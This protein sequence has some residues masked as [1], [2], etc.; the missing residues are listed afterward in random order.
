[1][2]VVNMKKINH[3]HLKTIMVLEHFYEGWLQILILSRIIVQIIGVTFYPPLECKQ[4]N[5]SL[6]LYVFILSN[7]NFKN[8]INFVIFIMLGGVSEYLII[9]QHI[10]YYSELDR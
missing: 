3:L 2:I 6:Q 4:C 7:Y 1:M 5:V 9:I 8:T 10:C